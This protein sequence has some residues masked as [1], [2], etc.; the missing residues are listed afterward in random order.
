MRKG[1]DSSVLTP[2]GNACFTVR[3]SPKGRVMP[4]LATRSRGIMLVGRPAGQAVAGA[5]EPMGPERAVERSGRTSA[6]RAVWKEGVWKRGGSFTCASTCAALGS[7]RV[8]AG[9]RSKAGQ[10]RARAANTSESARAHARAHARAR[11]AVSYQLRARSRYSPCARVRARACA[12]APILFVMTPSQSLRRPMTTASRPRR[13]ASSAKRH[14]RVPTAQ[15]ATSCIVFS[16]AGIFCLPLPPLDLLMH[17]LAH[18][19]L[20]AAVSWAAVKLG[21][22]VA[23]CPGGSS[24]TRGRDGA[25]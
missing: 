2:A 25:P 19:L 5:R 11:S 10:P 14:V 15:G 8:K 22:A 12:L 1:S 17:S 24:V 21:G 13:T 6:L 9:H 23:H 20:T 18:V 7:H 4:A 3:S 16:D